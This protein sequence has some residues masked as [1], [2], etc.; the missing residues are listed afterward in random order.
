M[1]S[2]LDVFF[3]LKLSHKLQENSFSSSPPLYFS[4]TLNLCPRHAS[5]PPP[6]LLL[7]MFPVWVTREIQIMS[8]S[9]SPSLLLLFLVAFALLLSDPQTLLTS[10]RL[11]FCSHRRRRWSVSQLFPLWGNFD[12]RVWSLGSLGA[13]ERE[14][15]QRSGTGRE[16]DQSCLLRYC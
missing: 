15:Q 14:E 5:P 1:P 2:F 8:F 3:V 4:L 12:I 6:L 7:I 13:V 11:L 16:S 10:R 9:S